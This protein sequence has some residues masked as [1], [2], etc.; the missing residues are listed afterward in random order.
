MEPYH[1][2]PPAKTADSKLKKAK[3]DGPFP[4]HLKSYRTHL[5][6]AQEKENPYSPATHPRLTPK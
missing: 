5:N 4:P 1:R 3:K 2:Q 6:R